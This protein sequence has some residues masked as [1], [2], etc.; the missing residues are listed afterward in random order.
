M[1]KIITE[2]FKTETTHSLFDTLSSDNYYV[3][4]STTK[5][6]IEFEQTPTIKNTQ[7][8]KRDFQRRVL[9][10]NRVNAD[11]ARYMFLEN[12]WVRGTVYDQYDDEKDIETLNMFVTV[13]EGGTTSLASDF[14]VLKCLDN[15]NGSPSQEVPGTIDKEA[16]TIVTTQ[17]GYVWQY[18]F[19]VEEGDNGGA[20]EKYRTAT[21][22]PLPKFTQDGGGYG[23]RVVAAMASENVSRIEI[24]ST[25][26]GSFNQYLFGMTTSIADSSDVQTLSSKETLDS[27]IREVVVSTTPLVGRSL[28]TEDNAYKNMYLRH[29]ISGKLYTVV[30]SETI[31]ATLKLLIDVSEYAEPDNFS[32]QAGAVQC[33]LV[34]KILVS[35]SKIGQR[36]SEIDSE[37]NLEFN[38]KAYGK[39]DE[40]G[41][42][43]Q[44]SFERRGEHYKF[45][46]AKVIY[47]PFLKTS[48]NASGETTELRVVLSPKGGH[49]S[50]PIAELAM[51]R[52][53]VVTNFTGQE[54]LDTPTTNTYTIVGLV[55]NPVMLDENGNS[56]IPSNN[57][58]PHIIDNRLRL[59]TSGNI[60]PNQIQVGHTVEQYIKTIPLGEAVS[61]VSYTIVDAGNMLD[62]DFQGLG[63]ANANLG[64]VF[65]STSDIVG[66]DSSKKAR[67]SFAT[68]SV[69]ENAPEYDYSIEKIS[70][71]IHE[72]TYDPNYNVDSGQS[73]GTTFVYL[74]DFFGDF[75]SKFQK[76][77]FYI[78]ETDTAEVSI[79]NEVATEI[80]YGEYQPYTGE[81]LHFIDFS[82]IPRT[83]E[84]T[85]K[86]KFTFDF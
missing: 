47:P 43:K 67:L 45:A 55:K 23:D 44:I 81:L 53:T 33:Q 56:T 52:L 10:A 15:N 62:V 5:T 65:T 14:M 29:N 72:I 61:G 30:A 54:D 35:N 31:D 58:A 86:I 8:S 27:G 75:E 48:V 38:C 71:K 12:S 59:S 32:P 20:I 73:S 49:G 63:A 60:T 74:H 2:N 9:F 36:E 37:E 16:G 78:K 64:T 46:T 41:T 4:A 1:T 22:L 77:I 66:L 28:Y 3:M 34:I 6:N 51:S 85:E 80:K 70:G 11:D 84:T 50:D 69:D 24:V 13:Q 57:K 26:I 19:N 40:K 21:T 76:G 39:L 42:L 18:M 79:N 7:R 82:P 83:E 17:D 68:G 25:P